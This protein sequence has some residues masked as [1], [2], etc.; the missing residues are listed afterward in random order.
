MIK[1]VALQVI[2][3]DKK[4]SI[5]EIVGQSIIKLLLAVLASN[6]IPSLCVIVIFIAYFPSR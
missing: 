5:G 1:S 3:P 6:F 4:Y 2:I